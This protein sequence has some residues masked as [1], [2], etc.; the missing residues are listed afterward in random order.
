MDRRQGVRTAKLAVHVPPRRRRQAQLRLGG[1]AEAIG[2]PPARP[3][4]LPAAV[5]SV[6]WRA[7]RRR[8]PGRGLRRDG[9]APG[10]VVRAR[11]GVRVLVMCAD[12]GEGHVTVARS[13]LGA[14]PPQ[15]RQQRLVRSSNRLVH[16]GWLVSTVRHA[17]VTTRIA[18]AAVL[19]PVGLLEQL[20]IARRVPVGHQVAGPL[21]AEDRVAGDSPRRALEVGSTL[22][23]V[24]EQG[25]V[26]QPPAPSAAVGECGLEQSARLLYAREMLLVGRLLVGVGRRDHHLIDPE[27]VVEVVEHLAD[28]LWGVVGEEGGVGGDSEASALGFV[29]RRRGLVEHAVAA[30]RLVVA[31]AQ[32]VHV[33]R[34]GEVR[35]GLEQLHLLLHRE[36]VRAQ[37]DKPLAGDQL[38]DDGVDLGMDERLATRDRNHRR[39]ALLHGGD[40]VLDRHAPA[41][42]V[43]GM[44]ALAPPGALQVALVERL[45]LQNER[46]LLAPGQ[47]LAR[48]VGADLDALADWYCHQARTSRGNVNLTSSAATACSDT[49]TGPKTSS[50]P[51]TR[52]MIRSWLDAPAVTPTRSTPSNQWGSTSAR[53]STRRALQPWRSATSTRRFE[54]DE[55]REPTTRTRSQLLARALTASWRF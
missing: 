1:R 33:H 26:V 39:P 11:G 15:R 6:L 24:E 12:I 38:A 29:N 52:L 22:E 48:D 25:R 8:D 50:A 47:P 16:R 46:V 30:N 45:E 43:V 23:E 53:S 2:Q 14:K 28:S 10:V 13:L 31:L 20:A 32:P 54:F 5:R 3:Q 35:R 34:P 27:L 51:A 17:V 19:L 7:P 55:L 4:S 44:L 18:A 36:R 42:D 41:Q 40:G 21:P 37:V 49:E 9:G